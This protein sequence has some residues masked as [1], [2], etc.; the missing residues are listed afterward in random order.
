MNIALPRRKFK[1]KVRI[2]KPYASLKT[3]DVLE[4]V[5]LVKGTYTG[6]LKGTNEKK[7]CPIHN[8]EEIK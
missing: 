2:V 1:K 3:G 7:W 6:I 4:S 5:T 8:A